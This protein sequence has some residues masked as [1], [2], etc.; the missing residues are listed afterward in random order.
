MEMGGQVSLLLDRGNEGV[1]IGA[2]IKALSAKPKCR[3]GNR[4]A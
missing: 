1:R 2:E 3:E 4:Y